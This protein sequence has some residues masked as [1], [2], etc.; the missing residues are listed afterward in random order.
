MLLG[1]EIAAHEVA[2]LVAAQA[3]HVAG[4]IAREDEM[5]AFASFG[6]D[7]KERRVVGICRQ[8]AQSALP[9]TPAAAQ[10]QPVAIRR[11]TDA[12]DARR[13]AEVRES[14]GRTF[15]DARCAREDSR[16]RRA[17]IE[18]LFWRVEDGAQDARER[19]RRTFG[20][21]V[22]VLDDGD[23]LAGNDPGPD[24]SRYSRITP[25]EAVLTNPRAIWRR[26]PNDQAWLVV[27]PIFPDASQM[28]PGE[29][30]RSWLDSMIN[31]RSS[32]CNFL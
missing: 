31:P 26:I 5:R 4:R 25:S 21:D 32:F 24:S 10:Q 9:R 12:S 13:G 15:I 6:L 22:D 3:V 1:R 18:R 17:L 14:A 29:S 30:V 16:I 19:R 2:Q 11:D 23:I 28:P 27:A 7:G 20:N 8:Q